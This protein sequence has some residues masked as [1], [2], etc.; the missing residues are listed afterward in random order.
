V[1]DNSTP[2]VVLIRGLPLVIVGLVGFAIGRFALEPEVVEVTATASLPE[3]DVVIPV[4]MLREQPDI[5]LITVDTLRADHLGAYGYSQNTSPWLD[6]LARRG[7]IVDRAFGGSSWTVPSMA[8]IFTGLYPVQHGVDKG[9]VIK[10]NVTDQPV[11]QAVHETL[12]EQL[13]AAGYT[14]FGI[15]TNRHLSKLQ[16][17]AQ[18]FDYFVNDGFVPAHYVHDIVSDWATEIQGASP[19]FLWLHYFDPHD[20]YQARRPWVEDFDMKAAANNPELATQDARERDR[21]LREWSAKVIRTLRSNDDAKDPI[22]LETLNVLYD[23]EIRFTDE[24]IVRSLKVLDPH[25]DTVIVYTSDHGEEFMDHGDFGHRTTLYNEQLAVPLV[26][27]APGRIAPG[28]RLHMPV[29]L[30]DLVPTLV[31]LA[32]GKAPPVGPN[33]SRSLWPELKGQLP[34]VARPI[35]MSTR[36]AGELLMG[37]VQGDLK[38]IRNRQTGKNELYDLSTDWAE[39][40]DLST[41]RPADVEALGQELIR[42]R[43]EYPRFKAESVQEVLSSETIEH[44]QG[45]GYVDDAVEH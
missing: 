28:T 8:S 10:G 37:I 34:E 25:P 16:G 44:L 1:T 32:T 35:L 14:T 7:A 2:H 31:E 36:R 45:L 40:H 21:R 4:E 43:K 39:K 42:L 12:A 13:K 20:R 23:S 30:I 5:I 9:L 26:V 6:G 24:W 41:E 15:A 27:S 3:K 29:T 18:G 17:F 38:L 11:L 19:Y 33:G 22:A